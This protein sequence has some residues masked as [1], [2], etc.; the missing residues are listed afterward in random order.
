MRNAVIQSTLAPAGHVPS[1]ATK[2]VMA[3]PAGFASGLA[4]RVAI[5]ASGTQDADELPRPVTHA[6]NAVTAAGGT[7]VGDPRGRSVSQQLKHL[8]G[9]K[10]D[11]VIG[12]GGDGTMNAA[13]QLAMNAGVPL[14]VLPCGTMNLVAKDL[15]LPIDPHAILDAAGDLSIRAI[16][17]ATA[18]GRLF[19][20]SALIGVVPEMSLVRERVREAESLVESVHHLPDLAHAAFASNPVELTLIAEQGQAHGCTRSV[21]ITNNPLAQDGMITHHRASLNAGTLGV[22]ASAH[23][24]PLASLKLL[25]ALGTGR[26]A[27]DPET[28]STSCQSIS[29]DAETHTLSVSL[30]GEVVEMNT[31]INFVIHPCS[32]RV[33]LPTACAEAIRA[34]ADSERVCR[35]GGDPT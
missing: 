3:P 1:Q 29:V 10:P 24:G 8:T 6:I 30:D 28:L 14:L 33:A 25:A 34:S 22:Y 27:Q 9:C 12:I 32:L 20:H 18:N 16:D 15:H 5:I 17:T 35:G 4:A 19:L 2:T 26:L 7:I 21:A 11:L 23:A 31:P 13:A